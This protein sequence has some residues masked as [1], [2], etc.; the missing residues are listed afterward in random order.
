MIGDVLDLVGGI[1]GSGCSSLLR[2]AF[3]DIEDPFVLVLLGVVGTYL[4]GEA[5]EEGGFMPGD[6]IIGAE[7]EAEDGGLGAGL[8]GMNFAFDELESVFKL[9]D[10]T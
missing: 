8:L 3:L 5:L 4:K 6:F 10:I 9:G 1:G 7:V 2:V